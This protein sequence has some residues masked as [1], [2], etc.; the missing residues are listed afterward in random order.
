[1]S[2]R[3]LSHPTAEATKAWGD[4]VANPPDHEFDRHAVQ[5]DAAGRRYAGVERRDPRHQHR[6][7]DDRLFPDWTIGRVTKWLTLIT[8][9]IGVYAGVSTFVAARVATRQEIENEVR[10]VVE[11]LMVFKRG[12]NARLES[13][14]DRQDHAEIVHSLIVPMARLQCLQMR[15]WESGTLT[16]AAGLPCDS[17]LRRSLR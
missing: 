10:P 9:A 2:A 6:R 7:A 14:E 4:D 13:I 11:T 16:D 15:R 1:M 5:D 8:L 3:G 12:T 17:L